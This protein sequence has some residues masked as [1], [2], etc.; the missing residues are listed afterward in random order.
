MVLAEAQ[1][2]G[3]PVITLGRGTA[4]ELVWGLDADAPSGLF[5]EDRRPVSIVDAVDRFEREKYRIYSA[6]CRESA[7]RF[8]PEAFRAQLGAIISA[9]VSESRYRFRT[10]LLQVVRETAVS[11]RMIEE[12]PWDLEQALDAVAATVDV[13]V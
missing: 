7:I 9:A 13:Y 5:F 12:R 4:L 8:R 6:A 1:G 3:L 10:P 2:C 11:C